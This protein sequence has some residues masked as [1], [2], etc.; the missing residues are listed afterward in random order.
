MSW[1]PSLGAIP[2]SGGTRFR[3]LAPRAGA[4]EVQI[5]GAAPRRVPMAPDG[6]GGHEAFV[7]GIGAGA[8]YRIVLDGR[9]FPDPASRFQP[10]GVHGPS[11]VV[12]PSAFRW[13]T[14]G[15]RGVPIERAV[16][17]EAHVGTFTAEGTFAAL[18][19]RLPELA[20]LGVTILELMPLA[21]FPGSRNW[22]YDGAALFAPA[23]CYGTPD[24]LRR[25]VDAAHGLGLGVHLD[26]V[27][28][29]FGPDG[30]YVVPFD[31]EV[32]SERH[33]SPWGAGINL[34]GPGSDRVRAFFIEN[35]R[36]WIHEY[37]M[38]GLRLDA[39]H[40]MVDE[41]P[42]HFTA[43]LAAR[44]REG[45]ARPDV[46][47]VAEDSRNWAHMVKPEADGGWGL[48]AVWTD[49][50]HHSLRRLLAGDSDGYFHQ[51][52]G[53]TGEL[54]AILNGGW[55]FGPEYAYDARDTR[56][57]PRGIPPARFVIAAQ[58]HDQVGNRAFGE[59]LHHQIGPAA[60]RAASALLLLA[61]QTP[62]LFMGQ[63]WA[64][65]A[66]FRFFTDHAEPLGS[67]VARGRIAE[68]AH[69][70][71]F[72]DAA[73]LERIPD[74]QAPST[75]ES[76]R[77][78]WGE[79]TRGVHAATLRLYRALLAMRREHPAF[80]TGGGARHEARALDGDTLL[81]ARRGAGAAALH[82]VARL[83]GAGRVAL[84]GQIAGMP[85]VL[86]TEA[87]A[88]AVDP[89]PAGIAGE[90]IEFRRPGAVLLGASG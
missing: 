88:Y 58:N 5:E 55:R 68:F 41:S 11:Q 66:P 37:R 38:D 51:L 32:F 80:E 87:P 36:H 47:V 56:T 21:D 35:A 22:G 83:R 73:M 17:Y 81:L 53:T 25:L 8:R 44:V 13:R 29:H 50:F 76:S 63:E 78:D 33:R 6:A 10:D 49:D 12:D 20:D 42:C 19:A 15:W 60:W 7:E 27:Y 18:E 57:D 3:V 84:P 31:P 67:Q 14:E 4:L 71:A 64:A 39:T 52:L 16:I 75:F 79:R 62:L 70:E 34:D 77:P 46:L 72:Q 86:D 1:R 9:P 74:P 28:N 30:A 65:S 48:D 43:E 82:L 54:A 40:A 85:R 23:R 90:T 26:V 89:Q 59:R 2:D 61:P 45:A 69:F 24:D